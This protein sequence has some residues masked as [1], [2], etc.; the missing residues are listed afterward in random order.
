VR[1]LQWKLCRALLQLSNGTRRDGHKGRIGR[2]FDQDA[3]RNQ[4]APPRWRGPTRSS[5]D[6]RA[7]ADPLAM[8][9]DVG[10]RTI[11]ARALVELDDG[12]GMPRAR[13][14]DTH[15]PGKLLPAQTDPNGVSA[16]RSRD[17]ARG[18]VQGLAPGSADPPALV[19]EVK[20]GGEFM[21]DAG[22]AYVLRHRCAFGLVGCAAADFLRI[23][24]E[25]RHGSTPRPVTVQLP[26][27]IGRSRSGWRHRE[28]ERCDCKQATDQK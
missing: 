17:P 9:G 3:E 7:A 25:R 20:A 4:G 18:S 19:G 13:Q 10:D 16:R 26:V 22:A 12:D 6:R 11:S 1:R 8:Q 28:R 23:A 21:V 14:V 2:D 24:L 27:R 15:A 5:H